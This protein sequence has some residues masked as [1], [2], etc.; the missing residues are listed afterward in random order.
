MV[1]RKL[2]TAG[3][4]VMAATWTFASQRAEAGEEVAADGPNPAAVAAV[5]REYFRTEMNEFVRSFHDQIKGKLN[6]DLK[7]LLT[8]KVKIAQSEDRIRG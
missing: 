8:P 7:E 2:L 6:D 4:L 3:L 1:A 5:Q